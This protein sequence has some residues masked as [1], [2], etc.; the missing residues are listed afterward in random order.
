V[1]F[2]VTD[3]TAHASGWD[4]SPNSK[5]LQALVRV[6]HE[7]DKILAAIDAQPRLKGRTAIVLTADHG[8][9]A[10]FRSHDQNKMWVDYIIPFVVWTDDGKKG[11][12]YALNP[13]TRK[14]PSLANPPIGAEGLPPVRNGEAGNVVLQLLGLPA[15]PGSTLD[16]KQDLVLR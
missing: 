5:Y 2:A 6:D 9:G 8:G 10:P 14:D 3:L 16:G 7:L 15:I 11:E 13:K 1:H 12:L 4:L